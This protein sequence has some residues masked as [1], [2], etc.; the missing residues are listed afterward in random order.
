M[1]VIDNQDHRP[2]WYEG[3]LYYRGREYRYYTGG[4][5]PSMPWGDYGPL[6]IPPNIK[7]AIQGGIQFCHE[8]YDPKY[9]ITRNDQSYGFGMMG[10]VGMGTPKTS[11]GCLRI[12]RH[13]WADLTAL[14]TAAI[15]YGKKLYIHIHEDHTEIN[16]TP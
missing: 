4:D 11:N 16:E 7:V 3:V 14:L 6:F 12:H 13:D 10:H 2:H 5:M 8:I 15:Q 1:T 9:K